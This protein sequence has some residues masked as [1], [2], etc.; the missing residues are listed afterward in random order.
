MKPNFALSLTVGK[1]KLLSRTPDGWDDL[2]DVD[3]EDIDLSEKL[4]ELH[5][6]AV[7]LDRGPVTTKLILPED[8]IKYLEFDISE[9]DQSGIE[10]SAIEKLQGATPYKTDELAFDFVVQDHIVQVAAVARQTLQEAEGFAVAHGFNP[11]SFVSDPDQKTYTG[12][13]FFGPTQ[14]SHDILEDGDHVEPDQIIPAEAIIPSDNIIEETLDDQDQKNLFSDLDGP[15]TD[16]DEDIGPSILADDDE[17]PAV[18]AQDTTEVSDHEAAPVVVENEP[19]TDIAQ[20]NAPTLP[21]APPPI[22]AE[23]LADTAPTVG[24]TPPADKTVFGA[25][26]NTRKAPQPNKQSVYIA[27][28]LVGVLCLSAI[29]AVVF[30]NEDRRTA[31]ASLWTTNDTE[32]AQPTASQDNTASPAVG[33]PVAIPAQQI[34]RDPVR[35]FTQT[36]DRFVEPTPNDLNDVYIAS[37]DPKVTI[38]DAVALAALRPIYPEN[39]IQQDTSP[40]TTDLVEPTPEGA[41][42]PEGVTVYAGSPPII[43]PVRDD[44]TVNQEGEETAALDDTVDPLAQFRPRLRPENLTDQSERSGNGGRTL[45]ELATLRPQA[46]PETLTIPTPEAPQSLGSTVV[47]DNLAADTNNAVAEALSGSAQAVN[48]SPKPRARPSGFG[49]IVENARPQPQNTQPDVQVT[50]AAPP[51]VVAQPSGPVGATVARNATLTDAINLRKINLIG[52]FGKPSSREALVRLRNGRYVN[53]SV[54]DTLDGGQVTA[55]GNGELRYVK[56][57]RNIALQMPGN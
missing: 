49:R 31:F 28:S 55:I 7:S 54:G 14:F 45:A 47:L 9:A 48:R 37:I 33:I 13:P 1:I 12:E 27:A 3:V 56:R 46:R 25:P 41:Q 8:Q 39:I 20:N 51:P 21:P 19:D 26:L 36:P 38:S 15:L 35:A 5:S 16:D 34:E 42:T 10:Q 18:I 40:T 29:L 50:A 11:V 30:A 17:T 44:Q 22:I 57:G 2:G 43:P 32:N 23:P 4:A 52:V 53:V 24:E 6:L